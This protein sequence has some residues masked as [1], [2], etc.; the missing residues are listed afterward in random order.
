MWRAV[1]AFA[2]DPGA[3][4]AAV[5]A[6]A[7]RFDEGMPSADRERCLWRTAL[8]PLGSSPKDAPVLGTGPATGW[9]TPATAFSTAACH[10]EVQRRPDGQALRRL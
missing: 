6:F 2:G 7:R 3:S 5:E 9:K 4:D 10:P 8:L 1:L